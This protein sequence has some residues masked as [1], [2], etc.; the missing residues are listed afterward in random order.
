M[1][2]YTSQG[3]KFHSQGPENFLTVSPSSERGHVAPRT[4]APFSVRVAS[5]SALASR[6]SACGPIFSALTGDPRESRLPEVPPPSPPQKNLLPRVLSAPL[7]APALS[8]LGTYPTA[9]RSPQLAKP[10][11]HVPGPPPPP[12]RPFPRPTPRGAGTDP[13]LSARGRLRPNC[14]RA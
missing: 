12:P 9:F 8:P 5:S 3:Q 1:N 14:P 2:A 7:A 10:R 4:L 13:S 11:A 6:S